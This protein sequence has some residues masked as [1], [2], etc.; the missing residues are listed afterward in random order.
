[1]SHVI[2][3]QCAH[4]VARSIWSAWMRFGSPKLTVADD[5]QDAATESTEQDTRTI[6]RSAHP[7]PTETA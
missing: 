7:V 5:L 2:S 4:R 3:R 1:M 6:P